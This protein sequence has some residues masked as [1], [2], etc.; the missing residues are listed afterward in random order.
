MMKKYL[1][2]LLIVAGMLIITCG[3]EPPEK[4]YEGTPEDSAAIYALL[5]SFPE[6][7]NTIDGFIAIFTA[8]DQEDIEWGVNDSFF[9]G[10]S[11]MEKQLVDSCALALSD[12]SRFTDLWFTRDTSCTV[13][14]RDT[15]TVIDS[16]HYSETQSGYYFYP[17]GDTMPVLDTVMVDQTPGYR[18]KTFTGEGERLIFFEP[19]RDPEIDMETGDTVWVI[20]EP[21]EWVLKRISYGRYYYPNRGTEVPT[22][23]SVVLQAGDEDPDTIFPSSDVDTFPGHAMNRLRSI[24][25]L[26]IYAA[27]ETLSIDVGIGLP[28]DGDSVSVFASCNGDTRVELRNGSGEIVLSGSGIV[29]L[30]IEMMNNDGY[31]YVT[32][33]R[34]Y[35]ASVWLIPIKIGGTQ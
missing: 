27:D 20:R 14:L 26:L 11:I 30:Y 3:E 6:L 19:I 7:L 16:V 29:N 32:P 24:D 17:P 1:L 2:S 5:D 31:Y 13:Y 28:L 21:M 34:G 4:F 33:D 18:A 12:S 35:I 23:T 25:S 15:F 22:I 10:D 8:V 9:K